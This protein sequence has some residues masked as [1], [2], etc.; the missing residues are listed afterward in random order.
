MSTKNDYGTS[1]WQQYNWEQQ[2]TWLRARI[3]NNDI[4]RATRTE[5]ENYLVHLAREP[6]KVKYDVEG[7]TKRFRSLIQQLL[8]TTTMSTTNLN[9]VA[10]F[11]SH[12]RKDESLAE[13]LVELLRNALNIPANAIR[14]TSV[15]GYRLPAG[16]PTDE[17]LRR[18]VHESKAFIGLITPSSMESAY[19]M[20]ELGARW[21]AGLHLVPLLGAGADASCL[22]G[23]LKALNALTCGDAAQVHQLIDDLAKLLGI[24]GRTPAAAY[25]ASVD[26]LISASKPT[27]PAIAE[28]STKPE[29]DS[30]A[31][32]EVPDL[33]EG[34]KKLL[35]EIELCDVSTPKGLSILRVTET[36]GD[37]LP[38]LYN[39]NPPSQVRCIDLNE[40]IQAV[41]DLIEAGWLKLH[42]V[43]GKVTEYRRS[44]RSIP[45]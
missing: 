17:A 38:H 24:G 43:E 37:Y 27:G 32:R 13:A 28:N 5:L 45:F 15:N 3:I 35:L 44:S 41:D 39:A 16:A 14:C 30:A 21:G 22:R 7:E 36:E 8:T 9:P 26:R 1:G 18:E 33:S 11:I 4:A 25:Q 29:I 10:V 6:D 42:A 12:S 34:A 23:P 31:Q 20:F 19:V 40:V 2:R